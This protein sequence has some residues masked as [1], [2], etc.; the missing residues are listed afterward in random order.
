M[1]WTAGFL[2]SSVEARDIQC[3]QALLGPGSR[4]TAQTSSSKSHESHESVFLKQ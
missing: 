4:S 2:F 1:K 3:R